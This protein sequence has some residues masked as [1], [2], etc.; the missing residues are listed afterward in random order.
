MNR[1]RA[2]RQ[3]GMAALAVALAG[4]A[5]AHAQAGYTG[6]GTLTVNL[7]NGS[8]IQMVLD[9]DPSGLALASGS[10][11]SAA[12]MALGTVSAYMTP[13][14]GVRLTNQTN[15]FTLSTYFDVNVSENGVT[16][17]YTLAA[18]LSAAAPTG[19]TLT[20]DGY[21]LSTTSTT[22]STNGTYA[23][24]VQHTLNVA[25]STASGSSGP[26]TGQQITTTIS[27]TATAQ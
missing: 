3:F 24:P 11:T 4:G 5:G 7:Q 19:I 23:T 25:I 13:P 18:L 10:G 21:T 16:G 9:S 8:G 22:I 26:T 15:S 17:S 20:L 14:T 6:S 27:L 12:Q 1:I 2:I